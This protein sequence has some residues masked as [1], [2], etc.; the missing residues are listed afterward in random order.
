MIFIFCLAVF[1]VGVVGCC[2]NIGVVISSSSVI[3]YIFGFN[4]GIVFFMR[5]KFLIFFVFFCEKWV[6]IFMKMLRKAFLF[7]FWNGLI[8]F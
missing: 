5:C 3:L 6:E 4:N 1:C 7:V 2:L 8:F